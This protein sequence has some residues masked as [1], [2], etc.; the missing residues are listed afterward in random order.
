MDQKDPEAS[1]GGLPEKRTRKKESTGP[2][3]LRVLAASVG[4]RR[5]EAEETEEY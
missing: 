1:P 2:K 5:K 3:G 4:H